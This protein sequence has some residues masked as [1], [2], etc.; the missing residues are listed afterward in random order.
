MTPKITLIINKNNYIKLKFQKIK[1]KNFKIYQ[2][3][4]IMSFNNYVLKILVK[5]KIWSNQNYKIKISCIYKI[6]YKM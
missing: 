3:R 4:I 6:N 2:N 5:T 1:Y